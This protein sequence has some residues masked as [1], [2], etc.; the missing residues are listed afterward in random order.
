L[1]KIASLA[2]EREIS[3]IIGATMLPGNDVLDVMP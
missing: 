1:C 2:G 3:G